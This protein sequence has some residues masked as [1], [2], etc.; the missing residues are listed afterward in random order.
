MDDYTQMS[1]YYDVIMTSGYYGYDAIVDDLIHFDHLNSVL[2]VGAG[3]GLIIEQ[4]VTRRPNLE[5]TGVDLTGP[6]LDI[7]AERLKDFPKVT[8]SLQNV[9]TLSLDRKYDLAFS[10]GGVW[11]FVQGDGESFMVSHIRDEGENRQGLE[12]IAEFV[13]PG[14]TLLLGIQAPHH[15][16]EKQ[17]SNGMQYS[18]RITQIPDGFRKD[19]Y[20]KDDGETVMAQTTNYRTYAFDDAIKL[21][22]DCGFEY[23][24]YGDKEIELPLFREFR[25]R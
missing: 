14:G 22:D 24:E 9:V 6:M 20:M 11:Y 15:D 25:R 1:K 23:Q 17:V 16:Y 12:R 5:V 19:Y 10:Y 8:L 2:E 4:L 3:T 13:R 7:A 21:L 18:Q